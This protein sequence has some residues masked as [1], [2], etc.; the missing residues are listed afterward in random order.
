LKSGPKSWPTLNSILNLNKN[1]KMTNIDA[2]QQALAVRDAF[3]FEPTSLISYRSS[4]KVIALGDDD[5]LAKCADLPATLDIGL[6]SVTGGGIQIE[7]YLGAYVVSSTDQHDNQVTYQG[8]AILDLNEIPLLARE[9]LPPGYFHVPPRDWGNPE[10]A[11]ELADLSGEF[12]KP[13]YFD[14]DASICAHGV[15][16]NRSDPEPGG[17]YR[18]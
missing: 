14:Y 4:G 2:R 11:V 16:G 17:P 13:K 6:V 18:G 3:E 5:A 7:G 8:D 1:Q 12:Q 9:M 10:L 15:N